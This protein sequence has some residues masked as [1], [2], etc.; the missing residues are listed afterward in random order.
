M[1]MLLCRNWHYEPSE[2]RLSGKGRNQLRIVGGQWRGRRLGFPN[3]TGL[4]PTADRVR[5]TLFNWLQGEVAG[6]RCLDLFAGSGALGLE[7]ASRG[8][9]EVTLLDRDAKVV[10]TLKEHCVTL[11][12][13]NV[14][15][16]QADA[17]SWLKKPA[18]PHELVF[19]D[20]PFAKSL[21]E[22]ACRALED[23]GWLAP[24]AWIYLESEQDVGEEDLREGWFLYRS[25]RSG[26][27]AY[28]LA[29]RDCA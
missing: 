20:P 14:R 15:V 26:Q 16:E 8:A 1:S 21:L 29:G 19:L 13:D 18:S 10:R 4:R 9:A 12:A 5:E 2:T 3:V 17:I 24:R 27:A 11:G 7:A 28:H 23:G 6:S 22:P 25:G